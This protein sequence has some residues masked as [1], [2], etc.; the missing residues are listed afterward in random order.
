[1]MTNRIFEPYDNELENRIIQVSYKIP[2]KM[3]LT[4]MVCAAFSELKGFRLQY[5]MPLL[6]IA[7]FG[8]S[9]LMTSTASAA[10]DEDI[11][12]DFYITGEMI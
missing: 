11:I 4:D 2:Q 5:A 9:L 7:G 10:D 6:F 12:N 1:M 3:S 8:L